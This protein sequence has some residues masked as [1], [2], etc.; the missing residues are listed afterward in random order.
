RPA[1][2]AGALP[3]AH[4]VLREGQRRVTM[5]ML[6]DVYEFH[7]KYGLLP[8]DGP[9]KQLDWELFNFRIRF[10]AEELHEFKRA[11]TQA[12]L[13]DQLDALVDL[14]YV[15]LGTAVLMGLAPA[16]DQAWAAVQRANMQKVRATAAAESKRGSTHDVVKPPGWTPPDIRGI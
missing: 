2:V 5:D 9:P 11:R 13:A 7:R 3:P 8:P 14:V 1:A 12:E 4:Q 6:R 10:L 15:A 16:W